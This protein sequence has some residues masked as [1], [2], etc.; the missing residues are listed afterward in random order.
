MNEK[1][2]NELSNKMNE[3]EKEQEIILEFNKLGFTTDESLKNFDIYKYKDSL[4]TKV[5]PVS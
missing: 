2:L 4:S 1:K 3:F 5:L